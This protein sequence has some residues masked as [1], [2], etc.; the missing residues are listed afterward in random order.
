MARSLEV[1]N[2]TFNSIKSKYNVERVTISHCLSLLME[3][4]SGSNARAEAG[5]TALAFF[6]TLRRDGKLD[7]LSDEQAKMFEVK[8][9]EESIA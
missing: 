1:Y 5:L 9:V 7:I 2:K 3:L 6:R 4:P 8:I